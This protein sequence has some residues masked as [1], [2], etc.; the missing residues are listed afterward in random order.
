MLNIEGTRGPQL[1]AACIH[2]TYPREAVN[3][4]AWLEQPWGPHG[5]CKLTGNPDD[6]VLRD[7]L[8][9]AARLAIVRDEFLR[10]FG[11][12]FEFQDDA[13]ILKEQTRLIGRLDPPTPIIF[14]SNHASNAL[15][16][17]GTLPKDRDRL[18]AELAAARDGRIA[19]RPAWSRGY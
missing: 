1:G 13:G 15:P 6:T 12:P 19:L 8:L 10:K 7:A 14:R 2:G 4:P 16:L 5:Y 18:L 3:F 9:S 11:E 17:A